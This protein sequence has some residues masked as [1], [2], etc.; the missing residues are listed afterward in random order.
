VGDRLH[1]VHVVLSLDV[2]GL[3][4]NVVNQVREGHALGQRVS[5]VCLERPGVL[6]PRVEALGAEVACLDKRPGIR[7]ALIERLRR[8]FRRWR[9]DVV[10]THQIPTLFYTGPAARLL[11]SARVVHTEH[12]LP[13]FEGSVRTRW[14]GRLSAAFCD[15]FFCL[16]Q[17]MA[18][19][20]KRYRVAR[21]QKVLL[22]RNGIETDN[23]VNPGDPAALR[24]ALGIPSSAP[25]IGTVG[26]LAEI[27]QY[28]VLLRSFAR[29]KRECPDAHLLL[30]GDGPLG[31]SLRQKAED[32][33]VLASVHFAGY[34]TNINEY[35]HAMNCFALPS[36]SE[37]TP[38]A[39]LEASMARLPVVATRVGGLPEVIDDG[40]TGILVP[41]GDEAALTTEIARVIRDPDLATRLGSAARARVEALYGV[42]RMAREYHRHYLELLSKER[43]P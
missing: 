21:H 30:V 20:V 12:G 7:L 4:R 31:P 18:G 6:A 33:G 8:V 43:T 5:V 22:I 23:Y 2:G 1:V 34:R 28:D 35:L 14:L 37:G 19:A 15:R 39:V 9:P 38:Q 25:V 16:T 13:L 41:S 32:L 17:E 3:E 26:R 36:R 27:K 24:A 40:R 29:F 10:H 11:G 42:A